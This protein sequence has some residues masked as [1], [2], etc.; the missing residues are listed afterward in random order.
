MNRLLSIC[1]VASA[2]VLPSICHADFFSNI[3][4]NFANPI[5]LAG[6]VHRD[7]SPQ[8]TLVPSPVVVP[9]PPS[10]TVVAETDQIKLVN[11]IAELSKQSAENADKNSSVA[12]ALVIGAILLGILASIA[13]FCKASTLAGILSI[14]TTGAVGAN[15]AL[16]FREHANTYRVVSVQARALEVDAKLNTSMTKESYKAYTQKL[17]A[18]AIIGDDKPATGSPEE[19]E[20]FLEQL[21][22]T[23]MTNNK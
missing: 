3:A 10:S 6:Q 2:L 16:P 20:H 7:V 1:V 9:P 8:P 22:S 14:L 4:H 15:N 13:G 11:S 21:H 18:L 19:L 17:Y 12:L 5:N 23:G